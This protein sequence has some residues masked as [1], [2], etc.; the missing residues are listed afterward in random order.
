MSKKTA[1]KDIEKIMKDLDLY[2]DKDHYVMNQYDL[3]E[4]LIIT[5]QKALKNAEKILNQTMINS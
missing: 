2:K 4:V 3:K 5:Y 1:S